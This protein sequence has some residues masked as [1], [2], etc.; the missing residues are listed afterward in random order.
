MKRLY[1]YLDILISYAR[2]RQT[3]IKIQ[4]YYFYFVQLNFKKMRLLAFII[5]FLS[6]VYYL[7]FKFKIIISIY[8]PNN[9]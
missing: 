2:K 1:Y 6:F 8:L 4:K 7:F 5:V 9:L 3:E